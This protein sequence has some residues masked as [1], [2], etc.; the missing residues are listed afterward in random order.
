MYSFYMIHLPGG[1]SQTS[2]AGDD[3]LK[4]FLKDKIKS[5]SKTVEKLNGRCVWPIGS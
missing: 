5:S 2:M 3:V 4:S 1:L